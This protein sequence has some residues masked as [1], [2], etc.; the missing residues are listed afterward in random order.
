M[1]KK[2]VYPSAVDWWWMVP[3]MVVV[4]Y[5]SFDDIVTR[6]QQG[7]VLDGWIAVGVVLL[8]VVLFITIII[9]C[10]YTL[11]DD[12]LLIQSGLIKTKLDYQRMRDVK[13][14]WNPL[15][16]PALSLKRVKIKLDRGFALISPKHRDEFIVELKRRIYLARESNPRSENTP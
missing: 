6:F 16:A 14:S 3:L 8:V 7:A 13:P 2:H 1:N 11:A 12:G 9:P 5:V 15:S 10:R 4:V